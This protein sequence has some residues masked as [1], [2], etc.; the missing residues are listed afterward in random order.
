VNDRLVAA[1]GVA[2]ERVEAALSALRLDGDTLDDLPL[3]RLPDYLWPQTDI[4]LIE[5][6]QRSSLPP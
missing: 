4:D 3:S 1:D 2:D 6:P 5:I